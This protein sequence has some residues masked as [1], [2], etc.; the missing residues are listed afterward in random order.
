MEEH[1]GRELESGD[2]PRGPPPL[3]F[4][5][6]GNRLGS[7]FGFNFRPQLEVHPSQAWLEQFSQQ[8]NKPHSPD[9]LRSLTHGLAR[10]SSSLSM[11][12]SRK[13]AC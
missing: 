7:G 2:S 9:H 10:D 3:T 13:N 12:L 4:V 5:T 6:S 1:E 11:W 8:T